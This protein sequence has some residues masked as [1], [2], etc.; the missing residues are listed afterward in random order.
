[1][2]QAQAIV[3]SKDQHKLQL[4]ITNIEAI[5]VIALLHTLQHTPVLEPVTIQSVLRVQN[6]PHRLD[7]NTHVVPQYRICID[8]LVRLTLS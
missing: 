2:Q 5:D 4:L 7:V 8:S 3:S 1:M 6:A